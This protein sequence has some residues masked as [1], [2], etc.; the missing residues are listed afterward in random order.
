[1]KIQSFIRNKAYQLCTNLLVA[2]AVVTGVSA[3]AL[4]QPGDGIRIAGAKIVP[5][6]D[7]YTKYETNP[8]RL[9]SDQRPVGDASLVTRIGLDFRKAGADL[10]LNAGGSLVYD[11]FFGLT[12][13]STQQFSAFTGDLTLDIEANKRSEFP[14]DIKTSI[15]RSAD[16]QVGSFDKKLEHTLFN[17][18]LQTGYNPGGGALKNTLSA[19]YSY[20]FFDRGSSANSELSAKR[21]DYSRITAKL[22]SLYKFLPKTGVFLNVS[23]VDQRF[24]YAESAAF[25]VS[26]EQTDG[27]TRSYKGQNQ[28]IGIWKAYTGLTG[29]LTSKMT[30]LASVGINSTSLNTAAQNAYTVDGSTILDEG[31]TAVAG[32]I[33]LNWQNSSTSKTFLQFSRN[34][35]PASLFKYVDSLGGAIGGEI[36]LLGDLALSAKAS[37][38]Y[39]GYGKPVV[40]DFDTRSDL[41]LGLDMVASY[42][43]NAGLVFAIVN[44][45][46][47][48]STSFKSPSG[49]NPSYTANSTF[50][51]IAF[52]Y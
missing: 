23:Y 30:L 47:I 36:R 33:Q 52:R 51:R 32:N 34:V 31:L 18:G 37:L 19:D 17:V 49:I 43:I 48:L 40:N 41:K 3:H 38:A 5:S 39:L 12:N 22:E 15:L 4:A 27:T 1:V 11:Y 16:P 6:V 10:G 8:G 7:V 26:L 25:D 45:L 44:Q 46:E 20:D 35:S 9:A 14:L 28:T 42:S 21:Q 2:G 24:T 29:M 13:E 50:L